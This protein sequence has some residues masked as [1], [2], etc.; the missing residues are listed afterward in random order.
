[1]LGTIPA[2]LAIRAITAYQRH[3]SP[4]KGFVCAHRIL[5]G[6]DSCSEHARTMIGAAGLVAGAK[7]MRARFRACRDAAQ[8]LAIQ[9]ANVSGLD[10]LDDD[11]LL[12]IPDEPSGTKRS[13]WNPSCEPQVCDCAAFLP[14]DAA[15][16]ACV[17]VGCDAAGA[18]CLAGAACF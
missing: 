4:R 1:M 3:L 11:D 16:D 13:S 15:G 17:G 5:H 10:D 6:G 2:N 14:T 8:Q 9:A 12:E 7:R 18:D